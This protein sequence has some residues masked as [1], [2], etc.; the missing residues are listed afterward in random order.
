MD[1][2]QPFII[3]IF[4]KVCYDNKD[5]DKVGAYLKYRRKGMKR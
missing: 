5:L 2:Q 1:K 4:Y 3:D